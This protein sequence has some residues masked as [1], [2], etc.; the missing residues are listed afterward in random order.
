MT[1]FFPLP[2]LS[3]SSPVIDAELPKYPLRKREASLEIYSHINIKKLNSNKQK[4][5]KIA[6]IFR[7]LRD[8]LEFLF[9][10]LR[11]E[12]KGAWGCSTFSHRPG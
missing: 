3:Q 2:L 10:W 5:L 8:F 7:E 1:D 4:K 12:E 6:L 9:S 11:V